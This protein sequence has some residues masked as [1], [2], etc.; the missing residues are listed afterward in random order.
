[1]AARIIAAESLLMWLR[2]LNIRHGSVT[3]H[4]QNG[5]PKSVEVREV[6]PVEES[7]PKP[8]PPTDSPQL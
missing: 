4:L 1:M 8:R 2:A 5:R 6:L 3:V 7:Q